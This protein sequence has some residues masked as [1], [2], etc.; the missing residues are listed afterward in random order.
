MGLEPTTSSVTGKRS[1]QTEL[2]DHVGRTG[3]EPVVSL[4]RSGFTVRWL[5]PF[6]LPTHVPDFDEL[7]KRSSRLILG[8]V[9]GPLATR[10]PRGSSPIVGRRKGPTFGRSRPTCGVPCTS[11]GVCAP[12]ETAVA[13]RPFG[14]SWSWPTPKSTPDEPRTGA[15][16]RA[17]QRIGLRCGS[18]GA[19][20]R[21]R[22]CRTRASTTCRW[23]SSVR[24]QGWC[25]TRPIR[26]PVMW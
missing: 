10:S 2:T 14:R 24:T 26:S 8:L 13:V 22:S 17:S 19:G 6:A 15:R 1:N 11:F 18:T 25:A 4:S 20:R 16:P 9:K 12:A 5:Q 7:R 23:C 21:P 3:F